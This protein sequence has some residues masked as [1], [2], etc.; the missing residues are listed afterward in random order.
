MFSSQVAFRFQTGSIKSLKITYTVVRC[1]KFRFQTGSI[2][3]ARHWVQNWI[4]RHPFRFQTGSIK[5]MIRN[6]YK[7][8]WKC[9]DSKL[10]RLKENLS[11]TFMAKSHAFRFQTGSIKS[12]SRFCAADRRRRWFR[13]QTGSIKS[14]QKSCY[15]FLLESFDSK[16]VRLKAHPHH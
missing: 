11:A 8:F 9:F 7:P 3:S 14:L 15:N 12:I 5:S 16:L 13:F 10:V 6:L 4:H 2:K 1:Q